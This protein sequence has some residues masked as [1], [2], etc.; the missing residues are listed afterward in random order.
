MNTITIVGR[1]ASD[2][3]LKTLPSGKSVATVSLA[4]NNGKEDP[5]NFYRLNIWG[6]S[7]DYASNYLAKGRLVYVSGVLKIRQYNAGSGEQKTSVEVTVNSISGLDRPRDDDHTAN[8][9][10]PSKSQGQERDPFEDE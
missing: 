2:I 7:A 4:D 6:P 10:K 3:E 1:L 5:A 8:V 9:K